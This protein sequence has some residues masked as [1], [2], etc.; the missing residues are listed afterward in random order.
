MKFTKEQITFLKSFN[1]EKTYK[2]LVKLFQV[3]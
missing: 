3:K 2:E 1:G